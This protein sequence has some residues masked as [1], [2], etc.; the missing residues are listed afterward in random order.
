M[1]SMVLHLLQSYGYLAVFLFIALESLGLPLPGESTLIAAS[2]YAGTTH[3]L[4]IAVI[5]VAAASAAII[6]DN[7]GYYLG[8][9][10]GP[11]LVER[12]GHYVRLDQAK[13]NAGRYLFAHHGGKVVFFG[14]FISVLRT[15]AAFFAGM[16]KMPWSRFMAFN[17]AGGIL[18]AGVY[19]FGSFGLGTAA[20]KLGQ[21][22]TIAGVV[23]TVVLTVAGVLLGKRWMRRLEQQTQDEGHVLG[24]V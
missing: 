20:T 17:A 18:W 22:V 12:Y 21:T 16:S 23:A 14:R 11:R 8:M 9:T 4:N 13:L 6:G 19:A 1:S 7:G 5:A 15:Y 3:H 24:T 10:G 2:V